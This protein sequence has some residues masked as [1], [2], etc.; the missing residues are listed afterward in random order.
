VYL[1][2]LRGAVHRLGDRLD[3]LLQLARLNRCPLHPG[4][5]D[6]SALFANELSRLSNLEPF[7]EVLISVEPGLRVN[8]DPAL[9][10]TAV[11]HLVNNAWKF[12]RDRSPA[13]IKVVRDALSGAIA[14][15]D[16]GAGFDMR[17]SE[18]IFAPFGR[19][20]AEREFEGLGMGLS[21]VQRIVLRHG[22]RI[23]VQS[24]VDLGATVCFEV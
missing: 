3:A 12:S 20:H 22:G 4:P 8:A 13:H 16:N 17:Y 11:S 5:V 18:R 15:T 9:M 1:D 14:I 10:A 2:R 7:R 6:L 24:E 23:W 19:F 21:V